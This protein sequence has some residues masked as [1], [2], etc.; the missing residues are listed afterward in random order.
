MVIGVMMSMFFKKKVNRLLILM[1][2]EIN[3]IK[4]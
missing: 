3:K 2:Q 4:I 1:T